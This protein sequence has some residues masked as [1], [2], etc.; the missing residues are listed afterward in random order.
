MLRTAPRILALGTKIRAVER[1]EG[2][3]GA[4]DLIKKQRS[5]IP[6]EDFTL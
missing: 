3:L 5:Q 1:V 2:G 4:D 6:I